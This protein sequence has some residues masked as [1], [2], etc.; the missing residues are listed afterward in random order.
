MPPARQ[1]LGERDA[2]LSPYPWRVADPSTPL[3][4]RPAGSL[5]EPKPGPPSW[6]QRAFAALPESSKTDRPWLVSF[7]LLVVVTVGFGAALLAWLVV[8]RAGAR[9]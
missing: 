6:L 7:G 8:A 5:P 3:K 4:P 1:A 2:S 9:P